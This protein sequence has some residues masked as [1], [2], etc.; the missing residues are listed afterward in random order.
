MYV[1]FYYSRWTTHN[2]HYKPIK[3]CTFLKIGT[4]THTRRY[5]VNHI[6]RLA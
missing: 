2:T 5:I 4:V 3:L 1:V 6:Y